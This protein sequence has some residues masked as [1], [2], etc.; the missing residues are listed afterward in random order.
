[1]EKQREEIEINKLK[2]EKLKIKEGLFWT[3]VLIVLTAGA[4]FGTVL[5]KQYSE[6]SC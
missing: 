6:K 5:Y 4:G 3:T 1:M 2:I